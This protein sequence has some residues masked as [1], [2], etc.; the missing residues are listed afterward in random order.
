MV[1]IED[2]VAFSL[3]DTGEGLQQ[4]Y[5]CHPYPTDFFLIQICSIQTWPVLG[6][7]FQLR[8]VWFC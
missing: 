4:Q 5:A 1:K 2:T 7:S 6:H 8:V 3:N